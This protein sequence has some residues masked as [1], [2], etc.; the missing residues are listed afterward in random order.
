MFSL[1]SAFPYCQPR[2]KKTKWTL[3]ED[4][5]LRLAVEANGTDSW[6]KISPLV[7]NRTGKQCRERWLGQLSP[8]VSKDVWSPEEDALLIHRQSISGNKWAAI[9]AEM[10]GRMSL[11]VKN[12]WNW[13]IRHQASAE[14]QARSAPNALAKKKAP[15]QTVFEPLSMDNGLF[16][17]AFEAFKATML[18]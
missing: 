7:P 14:D 12:R 16:G 2:T 3:E 18:G 15:G 5:I 10:P 8:T 6:G 9:A 17:T 13:L 11:H 4:E 1:P